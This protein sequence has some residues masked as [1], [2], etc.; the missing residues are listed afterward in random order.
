MYD[1]SFT[2]KKNTTSIPHR[3]GIMAAAGIALFASSALFAG[4]A[5][6]VND[7]RPA[8]FSSENTVIEVPSTAVL[9][10]ERP[11][12]QTFDATP[13]KPDAIT[14]QS[15]TKTAKR[16]M[17]RTL[18]SPMT[19]MTMTSPFGT[20]VSPITGAIAEQHLGQDF[21][22]KC[23]TPVYASDSGKVVFSGWHEGGGGNRVEINHGNGVTT[24]YS[25]MA[26]NAVQVSDIV[27]V[28]AIVGFVGTTGS[29]TGCH[30][31]FET[32]KDDGSRVDPMGWKI[33]P[34]KAK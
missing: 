3:T 7:P 30:L 8:S 10:F 25:H 16:P 18:S 5:H 9:K 32:I 12:V 17:A 14:V 29:S 31:H 34:I 33:I 19:E 4:A 2:T 27:D 11:M 15:A 23:G 28:G 24:S 26:S 20:R 22:A 13:K 6:A 21:S 1:K